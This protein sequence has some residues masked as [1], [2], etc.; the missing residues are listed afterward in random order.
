LGW[1]KTPIRNGEADR[2]LG[3]ASAE[4]GVALAKRNITSTRSI[5]RD[6]V[7]LV[8]LIIATVSPEVWTAAR[9][10]RRR[11]VTRARAVMKTLWSCNADKRKLCPGSLRRLVSLIKLNDLIERQAEEAQRDDCTIL[12]NRLPLHANER[13][14]YNFFARD[15]GVGKIRD[16]R[17]IKD[18]RSGKS[19]G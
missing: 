17:L 9:R 10:R 19:K 14:I 4:V 15:K 13:E 16:V 6:A 12:V 8:T 11:N 7:L 2:V 3:I 18:Q 1:K 5:T